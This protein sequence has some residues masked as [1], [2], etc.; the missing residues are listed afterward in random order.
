MSTRKTFKSLTLALTLMAGTFFTQQALAQEI[1]ADHLKAA[2]AA[3]AAIKVTAPFDSIL[4][5][6]AENLKGVLIQGN[7]NLSEEISNTVDDEAI[8][9]A[10]RRSDLEDEVANI[11]A[12]AFS[13]EEL[14]AISNFYNTETGK[15]LLSASPII[16]RELRRSGE[17]WGAGVARDLRTVVQNSLVERFGEQAQK[18]ATE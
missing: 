8:K 1:T 18:P 16:V 15:K 14:E 4:P 13:Q 11:Y 5:G 12:K 3:I 7:P 9:L 10:S 6:A 2:R 17:I